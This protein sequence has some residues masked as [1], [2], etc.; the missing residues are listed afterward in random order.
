[1]IGRPIAAGRVA[2][3]G[4]MTMA[5][6]ARMLSDKLGGPVQDLTGL[7]GAYR[8]DFDWTPDPGSIPAAEDSASTPT[9]SLVTAVREI[10]GLRLERREAQ[11]ETLVIDH[12]ERVPTEN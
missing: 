1:M 10:L 6:V 2:F 11:V 9:G 7:E 3:K 12:I 4:P 5:M 8:I